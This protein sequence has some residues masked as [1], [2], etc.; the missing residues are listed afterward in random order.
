LR[1]TRFIGESTERDGLLGRSWARS[2]VEQ[3]LGKA[4]AY[5][6]VSLDEPNK[7]HA[8]AVFPCADG[9]IE[10]NPFQEGASR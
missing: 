7:R 1:G 5:R 2:A 8:T 4:R 6:P 3:M 9:P 10:V